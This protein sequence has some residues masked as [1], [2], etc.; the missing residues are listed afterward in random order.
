MQVNSSTSL[1]SYSCELQFNPLERDW[2]THALS[3]YGYLKK[4]NVNIES[5]IK[6]NQLID[7]FDPHKK[8]YYTG[9]HNDKHIF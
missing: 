8:K 1:N 5:E 4:K 2:I 6:V 9:K 3:V 7:W